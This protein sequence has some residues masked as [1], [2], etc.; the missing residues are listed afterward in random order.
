M[1]KTQYHVQNWAASDRALVCRGDITI[2]LSPAAI[3]AGDP[4]GAGTRG[5]QRKYSERAIESALTLRL[6]FPLPLRQTAGCLPSLFVLRGLDLRSPDHT[7]LSRRGQHLDRRLRGGPRRAGLHLIIDSTGRSVAG[8]G[9]WAT[10]QHGGRG[11]RGWKTLHVGVDH[12]GVIVA[13]AR[14]DATGDDATTGVELIEAVNDD[15]ASVTADAADDTVGCYDSAG[16]VSR[17]P[18]PGGLYDGDDEASRVPGKP[19]RTHATRSDPGEGAA[20][21]ASETRRDDLPSN[22]RRRP[23]HSMHVGAQSR[24]LRAPCERFAPGVTPGPRIT[25]FRLAADLGRM[26]LDTHRVSNKVSKITSRH[27]VPLDRAFPAHA[28]VHKSKLTGRIPTDDA[29]PTHGVRVRPGVLS[30]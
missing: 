4:D 14:T 22:A 17:C 21:T 7:T 1:Y 3:A 28:L 9:E 27:L 25:R 2:W 6:L 12:T 11:T 26:G 5:A 13:H 24:G 20:S 19:T 16:L 10:A 15:I 18:P 8:A 30:N 23:S 29:S